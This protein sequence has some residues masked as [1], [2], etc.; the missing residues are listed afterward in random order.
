M[1]LQLIDETQAM[2]DE[3]NSNGSKFD[4]ETKCEWNNA[5]NMD[6]WQDE[7]IMK[8]LNGG[9]ILAECTIRKV[10]IIKKKIL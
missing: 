10:A 3:E 9:Q 5:K 1:H 6:V 2:V 8:I 4:S 7:Q